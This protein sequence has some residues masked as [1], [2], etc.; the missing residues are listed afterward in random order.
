MYIYFRTKNHGKNYSNKIKKTPYPIILPTR[1][2]PGLMEQGLIVS[3]LLQTHDYAGIFPLITPILL[4]SHDYA[5]IFPLIAP[6]L[7]QSHDYAGIFPL[8]API[9][10]PDSRL[11]GNF[12]AYCP[13]SCSRL[14]IMREFSRLF[15]STAVF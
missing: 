4:Q 7:L 1:H 6:I 11:C 12:P 8:I 9:P 2:S 14:T 5:G 10:A 3:F 13:H 15:V